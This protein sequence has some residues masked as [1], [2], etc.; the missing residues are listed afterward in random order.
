MVAYE[1]LKLSEGSLPSNVMVVNGKA[2][3]GGG[4]HPSGNVVKSEQIA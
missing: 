4:M 2:T 1:P 3:G